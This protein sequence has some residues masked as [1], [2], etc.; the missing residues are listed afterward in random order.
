[1][2]FGNPQ[3]NIGNE[4]AY[5]REAVFS[6]LRAK[7]LIAKGD[8]MPTVGKHVS[9]DRNKIIFFPLKMIDLTK[10]VYVPQITSSSSKTKPCKNAGRMILAKKEKL[11][12]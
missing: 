3:T 10:Y 2:L 4:S 11:N 6:N 12:D 7:D 9:I 5:S 8:T 1:M